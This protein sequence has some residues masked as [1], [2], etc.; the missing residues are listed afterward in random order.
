MF[1]LCGPINPIEIYFPSTQ[2][3]LGLPGAHLS[4]HFLNIPCL[5]DSVLY[6]PPNISVERLRRMERK[7]KQKVE[8]ER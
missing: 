8:V 7:K 4:V 1:I 5:F 2:D 3:N 6:S